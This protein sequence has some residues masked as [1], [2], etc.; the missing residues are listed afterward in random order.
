[1]THTWSFGIINIILRA[2]I[3]IYILFVS[4]FFFFLKRCSIQVHQTS[5]TSFTNTLAI[6]VSYH[7]SANVVIQG[8]I[9]CYKSLQSPLCTQAVYSRI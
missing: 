5:G 2:L 6:K 3:T 8:L 7:C 1:M 4:F 9:N